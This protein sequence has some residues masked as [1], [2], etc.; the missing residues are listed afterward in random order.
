M[1]IIEQGLDTPITPK[2]WPNLKLICCAATGT[3]IEN[4]AKLPKRYKGDISFCRRGVGASEGVFFVS[5]EFDNC[6]SSLIPV[7]VFYEF[8]PEDKE[9]TSGNLVTLDKLD[10]GKRYKLFITTLSGF[11]VMIWGMSLR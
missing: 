2:V 8:L 3:F 4:A 7:S 10:V 5:T 1:K 11:I 6:S 9:A